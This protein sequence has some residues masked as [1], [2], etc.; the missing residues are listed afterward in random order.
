MLTL[1]NRWT[2]K[3][4]YHVIALFIDAEPVPEDLKDVMVGVFKEGEIKDYYQDWD[5]RMFV[6][7]KFQDEHE[8]GVRHCHAM[9]KLIARKIEE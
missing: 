2:K 5:I 1:L 9:N 4:G 7:K 3:G 6:S 8:N